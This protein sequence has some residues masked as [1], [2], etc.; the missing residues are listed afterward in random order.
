MLSR[1][2]GV[3]PMW[4]MWAEKTTYSFRSFGSDPARI[5]MVFGAVVL[6]R[7]E[8]RRSTRTASD[9]TSRPTT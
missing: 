1:W 9:G 6:L 5:P 7:T 2:P 4:S 3:M 8:S